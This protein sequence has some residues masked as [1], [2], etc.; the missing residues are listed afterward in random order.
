MSSIMKRLDEIESQLKS[1]ASSKK[2]ERDNRSVDFRQRPRSNAIDKSQ[3]QRTYKVVCFKCGL[4]GH[5]ARGCAE[6]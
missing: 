6:V 5:F 4:E 1:V 3:A 2:W